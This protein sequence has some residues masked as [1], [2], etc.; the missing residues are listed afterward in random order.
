MRKANGVPSPRPPATGWCWPDGCRPSAIPT[1]SG[2]WAL[3]GRL[4]RGDAVTR[5]CE[6]KYGDT[7]APLR[8]DPEAPQIAGSSRPRLRPPVAAHARPS[9]ARAALRLTSQALDDEPQEAPPSRLRS[10]ARLLR[11]GEIIHRPL[12]LLPDIPAGQPFR[13]HPA[14]P[15]TDS[16]RARDDMAA[17]AFKVLDDPVAPVFG[18]GLRARASAGTRCAC[19]RFAPAAWTAWWSLTTACRGRLRPIARP[20]T[21]EDADDAYI[22]QMASALRLSEIFR[23][24]SG[25]RPGLDG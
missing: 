25:G 20:E 11:R 13:R 17:A 16:P 3:C 21:I 7:T 15:E 8:P 19:R 2:W 10:A 14:G 5:R 23:D 12:Q 9:C 4:R 6:V 18:L 22:T 24:A 1:M